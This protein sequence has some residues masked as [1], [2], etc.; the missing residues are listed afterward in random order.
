MLHQGL[1]P[2][3]VQAKR[4]RIDSGPAAQPR[5]SDAAEVLRAVDRWEV[6]TM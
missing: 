6:S 3:L 5:G 2:T 1:A 4:A